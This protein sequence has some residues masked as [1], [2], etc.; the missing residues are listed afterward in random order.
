MRRRVPA[1]RG[2]FVYDL[3]IVGSGLFGATFADL[4]VERGLKVM[5]ID[6]RRHLGGNCYTENMGGIDVH[7]YGPHVFHTS[8]RETWEYVNRFS[9]FLPYRHRIRASH[10]GVLYPFPINLETIRAFHPEVGNEE[11]ARL[12]FARFSR[13]TSGE[14][15][16]TFLKGKVGER[17]YR[18][19]Y[20]GYTR[21]QW[22]RDPA[23]LPAFIA[24]RIPVRTNT[25]E[26]YFN[27]PWEGIPE[28]GYTAMIRNMLRGADLRLN[29]DYFADKQHFDSLA[30]TVVYTGEPDRFFGYRFGRLEYRSLAFEESRLE[31]EYHQEYPIIN[32]PDEDVPWTRVTEHK[33]FS[34]AKTPHTVI[35]REYPAR[36]NGNYYPVNDTAN[37]AAYA[38]YA[39]L[40]GRCE[41]VLFGGRLA[42]YKYFDMDQVIQSAT[43][44][45]RR[46]AEAGCRKPEP[47]FP[48]FAQR[49]S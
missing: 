45:F 33:H 24:K 7:K 18:A 17:L 34:A 30:E 15:F 38:R 31:T 16:E 8:D 37:N 47:G 35:T 12:L 40:A 32:Y 44:K 23:K 43:R 4:A 29:T 49:A 39:A 1:K 11:D 28:Q 27:D 3:L 25:D 46:Y 48:E 20:H 19:F 14:N 42:E 10:R 13:E 9:A 2:P 26:R 5:V 22:G 41:R 36:G 21:K 6:R